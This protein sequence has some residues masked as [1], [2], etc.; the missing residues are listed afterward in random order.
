MVRRLLSYR[1]K[2]KRAVLRS[3][4]D[5]QTNEIITINPFGTD[6]CLSNILDNHSSDHMVFIGNRDEQMR[7]D[8]NADQYMIENSLRSL[9]ELDGC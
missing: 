4:F 7:I 5:W 6:K 2:Y 9:C 8:N 3:K 1:A